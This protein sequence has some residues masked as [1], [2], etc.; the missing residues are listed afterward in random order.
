[1]AKKAGATSGDTSFTPEQAI[2]RDCYDR[3]LDGFERIGNYL[4]GRLVSSADLKPYVGYWIDDIA[5]TRCDANDSLWCVYLFAY[6]EFYSFLGVQSLFDAFNYDIRIDSQLVAKFVD[7]SKD[8]PRAIALL[9][10]VKTAKTRVASG[11]V[12]EAMIPS[13]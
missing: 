1:V 7:Q 13:G 10:H 3:F 5:D 11:A 9:A 8:K 6:V 12:P 2:I 4:S